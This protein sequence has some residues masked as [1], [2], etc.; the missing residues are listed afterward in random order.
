MIHEVSQIISAA[1]TTIARRL[2]VRFS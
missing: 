2:L 1:M